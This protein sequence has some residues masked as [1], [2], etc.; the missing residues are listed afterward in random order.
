MSFRLPSHYNEDYN[1]LHKKGTDLVVQLIGQNLANV[2][3]CQI[4]GQTQSIIA[5]GGV[6]FCQNNNTL[7]NGAHELSLQVKGTAINE[8]LISFD[9]FFFEMGGNET[10]GDI[11]FS[12]DDA[13]VAVGYES[14]SVGPISSVDFNFTG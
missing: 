2:T 10:M 8:N 1:N 12:A 4:D 14:S 13:S 11:T 9:G 5:S 7:Q 6:I 3:S